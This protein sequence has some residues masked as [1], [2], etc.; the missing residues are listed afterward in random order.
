MILHKGF[1]EY[2][3]SSGLTVVDEF[4]VGSY[5]SHGHGILSRAVSITAV[6]TRWLTMGKVHDRYV[7]LT[8]IAQKSDV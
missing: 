3:A 7:N 5:R 2:C 4:G 8:F 1:N 6:V